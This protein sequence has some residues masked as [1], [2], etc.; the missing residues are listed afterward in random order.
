MVKKDE[1]TIF[2]DPSTPNESTMTD[3][4]TVVE[5]ETDDIQMSMLIIQ[6]RLYDVL[7]ALLS[8]QNPDKARELLR[9]HSTGALAGTVPSYIGEFL[10]DKLNP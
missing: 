2:S 3:D 7:M 4:T 1:D 10:T 5:Q 6:L 9:L 8:E